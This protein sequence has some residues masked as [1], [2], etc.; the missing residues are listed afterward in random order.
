MRKK[1]KLNG[2]GPPKGVP[3]LLLNTSVVNSRLNHSQSQQ[4]IGLS[5]ND[6][7]S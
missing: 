3:P 6:A 7:V 2:G 4:L 1:K 5:D